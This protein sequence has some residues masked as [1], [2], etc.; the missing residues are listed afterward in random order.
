MIVNR[1]FGEFK[2]HEWVSAALHV[3]LRNENAFRFLKSIG[4]KQFLYLHMLIILW[5][6]LWKF[7][8]GLHFQLRYVPLSNLKTQTRTQTFLGGR[9][10]LSS[11]GRE[12]RRTCALFPPNTRHITHC[13]CECSSA[14]SAREIHAKRAKRIRDSRHPR[15]PRAGRRHST[16]TFHLSLTIMQFIQ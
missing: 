8:L 12:W 4:N 14:C 15:V 9:P 2:L 7:P 13:S 3:G 16:S 10:T 5:L 6:S 1:A 11:N